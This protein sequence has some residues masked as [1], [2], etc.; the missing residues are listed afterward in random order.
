[1]HFISITFTSIYPFKFFFVI[2]HLLLL[3]YVSTLL[4]FSELIL[5]VFSIPID[6]PF[7]VVIYVLIKMDP[8]LQDLLWMLDLPHLLV[9]LNYSIFTSSCLGKSWHFSFYIL[10]FK[11]Y[12]L[13][14]ENRKIEILFCYLLER[15][16]F[17]IK[18]FYRNFRQPFYFNND[19]KK[20]IIKIK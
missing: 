9:E 3:I 17:I 16:I 5:P 20:Y 11:K 18:T 14:F 10:A 7:F 6:M 13:L 15:V 1:M 8:L 19:F 4:S 12:D 2:S